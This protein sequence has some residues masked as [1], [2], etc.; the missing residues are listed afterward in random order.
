MYAMIRMMLEKLLNLQLMFSIN[1]RHCPLFTVVPI[2]VI[3]HFLVLTSRSV[4][5][6]SDFNFS[7]D[8][9]LNAFKFQDSNNIGGPYNQRFSK[10]EISKIF[11]LTLAGLAS[12]GTCKIFSILIFSK[13]NVF[14]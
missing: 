12:E 8:I 3:R 11:E 13:K 1:F 7:A 4:G 5:S 14:G 2:F 10:L 6:I 9:C